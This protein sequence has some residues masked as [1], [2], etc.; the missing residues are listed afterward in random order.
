MSKYG[1]AILSLM[2]GLTGIVKAGTAQTAP[3]HTNGLKGPRSPVKEII[4]V[5]K[6]HFDIGY[7][8]RV[9]DVVQYYRT[10][11]IDNALRIMDASRSL[12]AEQQ[13][14]WTA[15]GWVM[16]KVME[17]W[18]GQTEERR[19]K[20]DS[21]FSQGRFITHALP[22]TIETDVCEPEVLTRGLGFATR[23]S[24]QY[25]LPLPVSAKV[26]D[27]P[28]HA[29]ELATVLHHA[30]VKFLHI[31]CNWPS[32]FV[33]TPGLFWWEGPDGSRLLT[34]YSSTY[35]TASGPGWSSK[36]GGG[37]HFVGQG[38]IPPADWP[39]KIW[40]AIFVTLDNTGPP[41]A[42]DVKALFEEAKRK[43]P[44][45]KIRIGSMDDFAKAILSDPPSLPV[46][47][48]EM[49]DTWV[50]GI[51]CDPGGV[52]MARQAAPL[53]AADELLNTQ[54][55]G[56]GLP[57]PSVKDSIARAYELMALYAEHTWGGAASVDHYGDAFK[58][59]PPAGYADLEASWED[60][61]DYVRGAWNIAGNI[62]QENLKQLAGAVK[63]NANGLIVYNPLPWE[64]SGIVN[65]GDQAVFVKNIPAGGYTTVPAP[66]GTVAKSLPGNSIENRFY[67]I[68][69][70]KDRGGIQ[71]LV[72]KRT[73]HD[74]AATVSGTQTGQY[75]NERFTYEQTL[76]YV[77]AYQQNRAADW[78]H[79][80]LYKPGMISGKEVPYRMAS[81]AG[82]RLNIRAEALKQTAVL[83]M[84]ADRARHL[85][86]SR[87]VVTLFDDQPYIDLEITILDKAK[88]NWPEADWLALP[89]NIKDP[90]FKVYRPLGIMDPATGIQEGANRDIYS[91]SQGV[92]LTDAM[93][94]GIAVC[95]VDHPLISLDR[96]GCW[97][98]SPDFVP[99]KPVVY[100]NLYNN[101]WNTNYR[102]W[103]PGTW[104]SRVRIWTFDKTVPGEAIMPV[105]ALEAR[106]PLE[107][108]GTGNSNGILPPV[109]SGLQ[110]S[111]KGV[112]VTA[113]G[114]DPDGAKGTLLRLWEMTGK[115]GTI[116][117]TLPAHTRFTRA[118]PV[119]LR[120]QPTGKPVKITN[121][122]WSS[123][124]RGFG[125]AGFMLE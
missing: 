41:K 98:F 116:T 55:K 64:R 53:L 108:A 1:T 33:K 121:G 13:F 94:R 8:H 86:A 46:V 14:R 66:A 7:T 31:G 112:L 105:P 22:F 3:A 50:H 117:I 12:P 9:K 48:N 54:L 79:P 77:K 89:F 120:G 28:S 17:P 74:W 88:D 30:G 52:K 57:A 5:F 42:E 19:K 21:A 101:Q 67:K 115:T 43:L 62:R 104:S 10:E 69:L 37:E 32:G 27:M 82:G 36:W 122:K 68:I 119:N 71:S 84:P 65:L 6:T 40:P 4:V 72:D 106:Y 63:G 39:Y 24:K 111:R 29:G 107:L 11:M 87:L 73:G 99:K 49:P 70:D 61:T 110:L 20:L 109:Q 92:T 80:G 58:K 81:P 123:T 78:M 15:P 60:K 83:E 93:G 124:I 76:N 96:P 25:R 51:M 16:S 85:P 35:G 34:F 2:I 118:R 113:F 26:T 91:V 125:P 102:Y 47:R 56:W 59:L 95:P 103:Y 45:V 100:I 38:L 44:G 75:L 90:V 97:K 18:P 114:E 23:L